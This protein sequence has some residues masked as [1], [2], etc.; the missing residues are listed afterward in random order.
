MNANGERS[1]KRDLA[2]GKICVGAT[3]TKNS[4]EVAELL[5]H[6]GFDSLWFETE[7]AAL[8]FG[9]MLTMLQTRNGTD[10]SI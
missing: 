8:S 7:H 6:L 3:I 1:L 10:V 2:A 4:L 5:S 9:E